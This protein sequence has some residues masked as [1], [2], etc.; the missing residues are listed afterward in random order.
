MRLVTYSWFAVVLAIACAA[1]GWLGLAGWMAAAVLLASVAMHVAGNA[2]GTRLREA[3]DHDLALRRNTALPASAPLPASG[4]THLERRSSLGRLVPISAG[5]GAACGGTA[6]TLSLLWLTAS[7][8]AGALLG[9]GSSA[10]V[11]GLLGFLG[12]SFVE[13]VRT[14]I[15]ESLAAER[16][17]TQPP[18]GTASPSQRRA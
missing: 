2:I 10:V 14:S 13:I 11:G 4:P 1:I 5:I 8:P 7:S 9:G 12:A 16:A 18:D 3:T 15:R 6:G 17:A